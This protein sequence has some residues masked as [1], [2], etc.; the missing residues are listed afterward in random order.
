MIRNVKHLTMIYFYQ[1]NG[2]IGNISPELVI[3][4]KTVNA[5]SYPGYHKKQTEKYFAS[6]IL[7]LLI[8]MRVQETILVHGFGERNKNGKNPVH[9]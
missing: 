8:S 7:S 9:L 2:Q 5:A 6:I 4:G 1:K 3:L